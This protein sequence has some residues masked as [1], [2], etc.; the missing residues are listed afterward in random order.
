MKGEN[1]KITCAQQHFAYLD[2]RYDDV[3]TAEDLFERLW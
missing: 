1:L 3:V 2:V